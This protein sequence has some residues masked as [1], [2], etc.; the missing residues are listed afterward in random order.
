[1]ITNYLSPLEFQVT[2][3]RLPEVEFF[4]QALEIP[5]LTTA[6][7][8]VDKP[9][10]YTHITPNKVSY[11]NLNLSFI[12]DESMK[13]YKSVMDWITGVS[14]PQNYNQFKNVKDSEEG[15]T[16]DISI[17]MLNSNKNP[18]IIVNFIE[19][20]PISLSPIRLDTT[21][22]QLIYPTAIASF[23]YTYFTI[24]QFNN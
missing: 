18:N 6:G 12:V 1:M 13:N 19:C 24:E 8:V 9:F 5:S 16:S 10:N 15:L 2:V 21:A 20:F 7:L 23:T 4:T 14:F 17:I 3:K 22:Q 11:S